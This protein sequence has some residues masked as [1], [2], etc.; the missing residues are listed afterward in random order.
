MN[1]NLICWGCR[2][3]V[4]MS[5]LITAAQQ[6]ARAAE[7]SYTPLLKYGADYAT[8]RRMASE[9]TDPRVPKPGGS[10]G[11]QFS[12]GV[13][14]AAQNERTKIA[15]QP[16]FDLWR[17]ISSGDREDLDTENIYL[18]LD[19]SHLFTERFA[20]TVQGRY[21]F[22]SLLTTDGGGQGANPVGTGLIDAIQ[23][24]RIERSI[25][26]GVRLFLTERDTVDL[27]VG[28]NDV[29]YE[30][31][32]PTVLNA[33]SDFL[34]R[35]ANGQWMHQ[36]NET[37]RLSLSLF[38]SQFRVL[39]PDDFTRRSTTDN[40]GFNA[41]YSAA[42]WQVWKASVSAGLQYTESDF[43][44]QQ[45]F[46]SPPVTAFLARDAAACRA[47][48]GGAPLRPVA[49]VQN[50]LP[51]FITPCSVASDSND[52]GVLFDLDISRTFE[53]GLLGVGYNR[54]IGP[55][56]FGSQQT[57]DVV[58][59]RGEHAFSDRWRSFMDFTYS[60]ASY[61]NGSIAG[62]S[63]R[64]YYSVGGHVDYKWTEFVTLSGGYYYRS[65]D[66][67][68]PVSTIGGF[69]RFADTHYLLF[70]ISYSGDKR[71]VYR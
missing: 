12:I 10:M 7:L 32:N 23:S 24:R 22:D 43:R 15:M 29:E 45:I 51:S 67:S 21:I 30:R 56:G 39:S 6:P 4:A 16:R 2:V 60:T 42:F 58:D 34:V 8:N 62:F 11:N 19:A 5:G 18:N 1:K 44:Q 13:D 48:N 35:S 40:Y 20:V 9:T 50:G 54:T 71:T 46:Q 33:Y 36:L 66:Y 31:N 61:D 38:A 25:S 70:S 69:G 17:F 68:G 65:Q 3:V 41:G 28:Y 55:T 49:V 14:L 37:D 63:D 26:P 64:T 47:L 59:L 27:N 53:N 57:V 52:I